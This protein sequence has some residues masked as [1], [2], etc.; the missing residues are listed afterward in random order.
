MWT[1]YGDLVDGK[2]MYVG[3]RQEIQH[4]VDAS[5]GGGAPVQTLALPRIGLNR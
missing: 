5:L 1:V 2:R 3:Q 4:V